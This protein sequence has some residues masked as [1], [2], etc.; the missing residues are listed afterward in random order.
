[1]AQYALLHLGTIL[2][3]PDLAKET[4]EI[5]S[6]WFENFLKVSLLLTSLCTELRKDLS[7][8]PNLERSAGQACKVLNSDLAQALF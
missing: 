3:K 4:A 5:V 1:M 8:M 6:T 7:S 2:E